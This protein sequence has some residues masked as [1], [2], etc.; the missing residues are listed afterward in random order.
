MLESNSADEATV[1]TCFGPKSLLDTIGLIAQLEAVGC[2]GTAKLL[3]SDIRCES[4][5]TAGRFG[6]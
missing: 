5:I 1:N 3:R 2:F 4:N 6:T